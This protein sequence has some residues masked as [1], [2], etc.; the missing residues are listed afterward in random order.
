MLRRLEI[1]DHSKASEKIRLRR[2]QVLDGNN[3][4][5]DFVKALFGKLFRVHVRELLDG[6]NFQNYKYYP[7]PVSSTSSHHLSFTIK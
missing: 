6:S 2:L 1:L 4:V 3:K 7:P 5:G